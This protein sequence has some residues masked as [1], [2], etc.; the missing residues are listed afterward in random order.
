MSTCCLHFQHFFFHGVHQIFHLFVHAFC[1]L[2]SS[3][4]EFLYILAGMK[5][6]DMPSGHILY[7]GH[8]GSWPT[9]IDSYWCFVLQRSADYCFVLIVLRQICLY[10]WRIHC[11][12]HAIALRTIG[13]ATDVLQLPDS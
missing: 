10:L 8:I 1:V 7:I 2:E 13:L 4:H 5:G 6:T 3:Y 9:L 11:A 12:L